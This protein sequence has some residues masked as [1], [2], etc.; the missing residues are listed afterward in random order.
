M[1]IEKIV[2]TDKPYKFLVVGARKLKIK[3]NTK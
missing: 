3:E 1:N 2:S